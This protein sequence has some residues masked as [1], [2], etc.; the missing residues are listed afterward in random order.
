MNHY[1]LL[2]R[3]PQLLDS[4]TLI[5]GAAAELPPEWRSLVQQQNVKILTWDWQT[6][7]AYQP[8][9]EPQVTYALP[10]AQHFTATK[11]IILLWPKAKP[12]ALALISKIAEQASECWIVGENDAGGK[13]I[14]KAVSALTSE[15][16][17]VDSAR[18]CSF[19]KLSLKP[20]QSTNW[21]SLAKSFNYL[22]QSYLTL[23]GVFN[24]G[25][26]DIG[27]ALLLEYLPAPRTGKL[28]DLGCGSGVIGL[29][30]K[31]REPK[32][33]VTLT[34][35]DAFA[36]QSTRLNA[37]RLGLAAEVLASDGLAQV[38]GKFDY[39]ITNPPFHQGKDTS[40]LFARQ[41][42]AQA[43][44]HLVNDGQLWLVANRHLPYE[45]WAREY[46]ANVEIMAQEQGFKLFCIT[47]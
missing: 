37:A 8:L 39:I 11:K 4:D 15:V 9:S 19:W 17:K 7:Q 43:K 29:S 2:L 23:P 33:E 26:L 21:L 45:D 12:L 10:E 3:H 1:Q 25:K 36:L 31:A 28:L 14:H 5:V 18:H 6:A 13:S 46:F 35:V 47:A 27:T 30:M 24:H 41:L 42:F 44:Q 32:L 22:E 34:D 20:Q 40:Y 38:T 16:I